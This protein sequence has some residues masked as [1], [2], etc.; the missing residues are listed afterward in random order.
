MRR[1]VRQADV[2]DGIKDDVRTDK[3]W[4]RIDARNSPSPWDGYPMFLP[5]GAQIR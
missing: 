4:A 3:L 5:D 1:W 2:D